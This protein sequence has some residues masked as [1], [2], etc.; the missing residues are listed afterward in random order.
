MSLE[1]IRVSEQAKDQL[2]ALKRRTGI[3]QWNVL[4]RWAFCAS[5]AEPQMPP[6]AKVPADSNVEMSWR[7]FGGVHHELYMALLKIRCERDG[8]G[9]SDDVLATQFRL[10]LHR[11]IGYLFGDRQ[12]QDI[13]ALIQRGVTAAPA[14]NQDEPR[15]AAG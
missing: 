10:H 3:T 7:V 14:S 12:L 5:L 4:C 13:G 11:G 8:L 15:L 1:H 9:T 6:A 2:I